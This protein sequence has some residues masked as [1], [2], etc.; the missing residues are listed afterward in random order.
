MTPQ[1]Y[2]RVLAVLHARQRDLTVVADQVHK[3]QNLSAITRTCDAVGIGVV[4]SVYP[5]GGYRA[6]K[7]TTMGAHKWVKTLV[8]R[9]VEEPLQACREAG[10]QVIAADLSDDAVDY[11]SIDYTRPTALLLG[12]ERDGVSAAAAPF[13]DRRITVPMLGIVESFN[14]SVAAAIILAEARRQ[15]LAAGCY[16]R[17]VVHDAQY[18]QTL[19]EWLHPVLARFCREKQLPYPA[20]DECGEV[21]ERGWHLRVKRRA[22]RRRGAAAAAE[23]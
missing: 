14:V 20:L 17:P 22:P 18:E 16:V 4:H 1:R 13:I 3:G 5:Q 23:Q 21:A 10:M 6:H 15:R 9:S 8:H 7:G 11:Q 12:N 19:F 2:Q